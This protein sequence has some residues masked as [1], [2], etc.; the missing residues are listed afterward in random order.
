MEVNSVSRQSIQPTQPA[1]KVEE[2]RATERKDVQA[3]QAERA[4][5]TKQAQTQRAENQQRTPVINAQGQSTGRLL[6]T[7]A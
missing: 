6:N 1:K 5:E 4:T 2:V 7:S 3:R